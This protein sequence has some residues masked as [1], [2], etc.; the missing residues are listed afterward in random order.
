V[1]AYDLAMLDLDGVVYVGQQAVPDVDEHLGRARASGLRLAFIT[2]NASR[3]PDEVAAHLNDLG[4]RASPDDVVTSAQAAARVLAEQLGPGARVAVLG[5]P[6]LVATVR[7]AGL[8]PRGVDE[9]A[10]AVVTGYGPEVRWR[11]VTQAAVSIAAGRWWV[12]CN[13]DGTFPTP[14]G[15]APGHGALVDLLA[16]FSG[17]SPVVAGKPA[18]PLLDETMRRVGGTR[19]LM[20]G[21]RLDTDIAGAHAV[22]CDSLLVLTGV[23]TLGD[24]AT[25]PPGLRPTYVAPTLAALFEPQPAP[26]RREDV[27]VGKGWRVDVSEPRLEVRGDGTAADWWRTVTAALWHRFDT[28]GAAADVA[29]LSPPQ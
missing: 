4:V 29:H 18:R 2:N 21:D 16:R 5:S 13:T 20:V 9:P 26:E 22:G 25:T 1:Q 28:T 27:V 24:L 8:E 23:T 15:L 10:D 6:A 3:T 12:A 14:A 17:V 19:P 11:E 7:A